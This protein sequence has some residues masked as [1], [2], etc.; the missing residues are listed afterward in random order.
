MTM[1]III[2]AILTL[3][4][5]GCFITYGHKERQVSVYDTKT[6]APASNLKIGY[7]HVIPGIYI[8]RPPDPVAGQLNEHGSTTLNFPTTT[9]AIRVGEESVILI[10]SEDI[11]NGGAFEM[12][13]LPTMLGE[14]SYPPSRWTL[15]IQK[16]EQG[17]GGQ[18]A[19]P[20]RVAD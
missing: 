7:S 19:T 1:R 10:D 6:K 12:H 11:K 16:P 17:V 3:S 20:S 9:G 13:G 18:P 15:Q 4:Q 8:P 5:T 14:P 2:L